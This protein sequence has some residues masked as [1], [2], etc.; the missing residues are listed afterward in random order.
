MKTGKYILS[1]SFDN[2]WKIE[3]KYEK[4]KNMK[5]HFTI[6]LESHS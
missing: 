2:N 1:N 4:K 6:I 3:E 5:Q